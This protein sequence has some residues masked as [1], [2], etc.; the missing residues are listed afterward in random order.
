MILRPF[1]SYYGS[2]WQLAP[3]YPKPKYDTIIEPFAGSAGYSLCYSDRHIVLVD[4]DPVIVAI[5]RWLLSAKP[6]DIE[7][8]PE[9]VKGESLDDYDLPQ[10]AK[11]LMGFWIQQTDTT[12]GKK[13]TQFGANHWAGGPNTCAFYKQRA[14]G[15]LP[16][17][18]H[19]TVVEA[20]YT[21]IGLSDAT[22]FIDP[23]YK[24]YASKPYKMGCNKI[25][26][27]SLADWCKSRPGQVI[28]CEHG[29]ASWLQFEPLADVMS[30]PYKGKRATTTEVVWLNETN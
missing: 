16:C 3:K 14:I 27:G 5:W 22:W 7:A 8:L 20:D 26:Y 28:V 1:F 21:D 6:N 23:P 12:P 10:E 2:K 9:L 13:V 15:Q 30:T 19:W 17:I 11:W 25:D 4:K 29:D 24:V 18:Q